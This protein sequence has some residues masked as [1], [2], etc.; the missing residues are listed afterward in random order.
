MRKRQHPNDEQLLQLIDPALGE[1]D[2]EL[3]KTQLHVDTCASCTRRVGEL[4]Y[5]DG[6][7]RQSDV[8]KDRRATEPRRREWAQ[9][10]SAMAQQVR[11]E[12]DAAEKVVAQVI[13]GPSSWWR[14]RVEQAQGTRTCGF[15]RALL[16]RAEK[17]TERSPADAVEATAIAVEIAEELR[18]DAYPFDMVI[19]LRAEALREYAYSLFYVGRFPE[20]L[21]AV[22]RA[23][24]LYG[25]LPLEAVDLARAWLT[26]AMI[27]RVTDRPA[28]GI[29]LTRQAASVFRGFGV[30]NRYA[31]ARLIEGLMLQQLGQLEEALTVWKSIEDEP[32]LRRD[33]SFGML[34][35][36][37]GTTYHQAGDLD[38]AQEYLARALQEY[39]R[40]GIETEK[41]RTRWSMA[42]TLIAG[43]RM[44][45]ALPVLRQTWREFEALGMHIPGALVGLEIAEVLLV[46]G[47]PDDVPT[48]CRTI[49]DQF[50]RVGMTSRAVTAL[51]FLREAVAL[52]KGTPSL[53]R[54]VH[55][56]IRDLPSHPRTF[57]PPPV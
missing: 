10:A 36:N 54:Q 33:A 31:K 46:M 34:L 29:E 56:F 24:H 47:K 13:T 35:H 30:S 43:G 55:D 12:T 57:I 32:V 50:M 18:V 2:Q 8:W 45:E 38:F 5:F 26:R 9:Q 23:E 53:V 25:Q 7:L 14:K 3:T 6:L 37:I 51:S 21:K 15:V 28:E 20:A 17:L 44:A 1:D 39:E 11:A 42:S 27:Y 48:I 49:L 41:V 22:E 19:S 4:R 52:G 40:Q 16:E